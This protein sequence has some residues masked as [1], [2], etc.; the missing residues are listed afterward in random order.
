MGR[1][2]RPPDRVLSVLLTYSPP[3]MTVTRPPLA[4]RPGAMLV[5]ASTLHFHTESLVTFT[6]R[7]ED[8]RISQRR[9]RRAM[10]PSLPT[11][12]ESMPYTATF[13]HS[14]IDIASSTAVVHRRIDIIPFDDPE[15]LIQTFV[16]SVGK[17]AQR[18]HAI[19][20]IDCASSMRDPQSSDFTILGEPTTIPLQPPTPLPMPGR[21]GQHTGY[22]YILIPQAPDAGAVRPQGR[23]P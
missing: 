2:Y 10:L 8:R 4:N 7:D 22:P 12:S 23:G 5:W 20:P 6:R 9:L 17:G 14:P 13:T 16:A 21:R 3:P 11:T 19:L 18:G 15:A 1:G